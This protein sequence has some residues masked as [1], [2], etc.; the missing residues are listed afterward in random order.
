MNPAVH[1]LLTH[2]IAVLFVAVLAEQAGL[3]VPSAPMLLAVGSLASL[4]R[5]N[6][7]VAIGAALTACLIADCFWYQVGRRRRCSLKNKSAEWQLKAKRRMRFVMAALN[8]HELG[9]LLLAKFL[10]GPN[11]VSPLAGI[12]GLA[13]GPFLIFDGIASVVWASGYITVGYIF[14]MKLR[15]IT[16]SGARL[17]L[18]LLAIVTCVFS[19]VAVVRFV[20]HHYT[21]WRQRA[22]EVSG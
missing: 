4:G 21:P 14:S 17:G 8:H 11:L 6:L 5:M 10:P 3:P 19:A 13:I 15:C 7:T 2:G 18:V 9:A 12:S 1:F 22:E 16:A 20:R